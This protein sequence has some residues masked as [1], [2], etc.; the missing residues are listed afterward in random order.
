MQSLEVSGVVRLIYRSLGVKGLR[1]VPA[2]TQMRH[3]VYS[4]VTSS[5]VY[6]ASMDCHHR[7]R[8]TG[9]QPQVNYRDFVVLPSEQYLALHLPPPPATLKA[10]AHK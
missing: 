7:R 2:R 3:A 5:S 8:E 4:H 1:Q 9:V 10:T 6:T